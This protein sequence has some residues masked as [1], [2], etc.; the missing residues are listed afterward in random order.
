[1]PSEAGNPERALHWLVADA[2]EALIPLVD[3]WAADV[4]HRSP[5]RSLRAEAAGYDAGVQAMAAEVKDQLVERVLRL[6]G[7]GK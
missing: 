7:D 3:V 1:M 6:R 5:G 2:L 4:S